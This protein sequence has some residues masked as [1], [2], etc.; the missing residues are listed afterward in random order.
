MWN[1]ECFFFKTET[2]ERKG[3]SKE[4]LKDFPKI[5]TKGRKGLQTILQSHGNQDSVVHT[6]TK[7]DRQTNGTE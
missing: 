2:K 4:F 1:T 7:T 3:L 5:K 6:G